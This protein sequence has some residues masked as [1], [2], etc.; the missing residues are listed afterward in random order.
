VQAKWLILAW[1]LLNFTFTFTTDVY[2]YTACDIFGQQNC[3]F[4]ATANVPGQSSPWEPPHDL[5]FGKQRALNYAVIVKD[6]RNKL[7]SRALGT[8]RVDLVTCGPVLARWLEALLGALSRPH[9]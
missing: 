4:S 8:A 1:Q 6:R 7:A 2:S 3:A 9:L 5:S